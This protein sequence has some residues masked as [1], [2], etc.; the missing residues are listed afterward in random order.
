[1]T[2]KQWAGLVAFLVGLVLATYGA[3]RIAWHLGHR[4][5]GGYAW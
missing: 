5:R 1:M 3:A 2:L 4:D